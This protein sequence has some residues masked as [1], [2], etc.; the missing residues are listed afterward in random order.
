MVWGGVPPPAGEPYGRELTP[1]F[2]VYKSERTTG[3]L[4][5]INLR[6]QNGRNFLRDE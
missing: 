1:P 2:A 5:A 6:I 4:D 3:S